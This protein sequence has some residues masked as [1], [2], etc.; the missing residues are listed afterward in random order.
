MF[1]LSFAELAAVLVVALIVVGPE[2]LPTVARTI[3]TL[4]GRARRYLAEVKSE[5]ERE[6]DLKEMQQLRDSIEQEAQQ[7]QTAVQAEFASVEEHAKD[8]QNTLH[9]SAQQIHDTLRQSAADA[10]N[11]DSTA[12]N[13]TAADADDTASAQKP[14]SPEKPAT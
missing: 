2:R 14:H 8:L 9:D 11:A 6:I 10:D 4:L 12:A 3:G 1:D 7:M 5:V 13:D